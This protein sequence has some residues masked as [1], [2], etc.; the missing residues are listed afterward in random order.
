MVDVVSSGIG[1]LGN[2]SDNLNATVG[3]Q[4]LECGKARAVL[5]VSRADLHIQKTFVNDPVPPGVTCDL[6]FTITNYDRDFSATNI[7][8][9][10]DLNA[11][12]FGLIATGL[13][14]NVCGGTLSSSDGGMTVNFTGGVLAPGASCTFA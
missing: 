4:S 2:T 8:F 13:P 3:V 14:L 5:E 1:N 12:L 10:D 7:S 9:S 11:A 6:Q